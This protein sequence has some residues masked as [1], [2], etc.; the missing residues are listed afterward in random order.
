MNNRRKST[1]SMQKNKDDIGKVI[2]EKQD[3][4]LSKGTL[5]MKVIKIYIL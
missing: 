2:Q 3:L 5:S 4:K 1:G